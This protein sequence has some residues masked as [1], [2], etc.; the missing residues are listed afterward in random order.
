MSVR[1]EP[2]SHSSRERTCCEWER[3]DSV[4]QL[5]RKA[6]LLLLCSSPWCAW[7][8]SP[9]QKGWEGETAGKLDLN[10]EILAKD[11]EIR[12]TKISRAF[13]GL[14][15]EI[16]QCVPVFQKVFILC[17]RISP[18]CRNSSVHSPKARSFSSPFGTALTF[19]GQL[20]LQESRLT[21]SIALSS[22][23]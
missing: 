7:P 17:K 16:P 6:E 22:S 8:P 20:H 3:W 18:C 21:Q 9:L 23:Y 1:I 5:E 15:V 10:N 14:E 12:G 4:N 11:M 2:L 13:S 19:Q